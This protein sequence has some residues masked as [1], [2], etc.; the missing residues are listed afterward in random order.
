MVSAFQVVQCRCQTAAQQIY[1]NGIKYLRAL[2]SHI[3]CCLEIFIAKKFHKLLV[4]NIIFPMCLEV[5]AVCINSKS[6]TGI[7]VHKNYANHLT[8]LHGNCILYGNTGPK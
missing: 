3:F 2:A 1:L 7:A 6:P 4:F 5:D 8:L